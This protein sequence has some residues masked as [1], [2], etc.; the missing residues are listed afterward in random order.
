MFKNDNEY[1]E[2]TDLPLLKRRGTYVSADPEI[3]LRHQRPVQARKKK[4]KG[5][6][7]NGNKL[8]PKSVQGKRI[9]F[10]NTCP[11]DSNTE[12]LSNAYCNIQAFK[13]FIDGSTNLNTA[14]RYSC[15]PSAIVEYSTS[16]VNNLLYANRTHILSSILGIQS[17]M[18][19]CAANAGTMFSQLMEKCKS[20]QEIVDCQI[21]GLHEER[22]K[23]VIPIP[24]MS[25][26]RQDSYST[27]QKKLNEYFTS[28]IVYC[29]ECKASR[30]S[31]TYSLGSYLYIDT[32][33][34]YE[35]SCIQVPPENLT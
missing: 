14:I 6:V 9:Y 26:V 22:K 7:Q 21:C 19:N 17:G 24:N 18:I 10:P 30:A 1:I 15:Y 23:Y 35:T 8:V 32:E 20:C 29:K 16:G 11:F 13:D 4:G 3:L 31:L 28:K 25:I 2:R 27:L 5:I 34:A 12:V 33:D